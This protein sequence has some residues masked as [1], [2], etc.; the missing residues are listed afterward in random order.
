VPGALASEIS[1]PARGAWIDMVG[2]L[3]QETTG[4]LP[5]RGYR[6][7]PR[8]ATDLRLVSL[9]VESVPDAEGQSAE[10]GE[11]QSGSGPAGDLDGLLPGANG[12]TAASGVVRA[13]LVHGGW[14]E[15]GL[16][17]LLWDGRNLVGLVD[18]IVAE[19]A[20]NDALAGAGAP[21]GVQLQARGAEVG[22]A[23]LH[24][25][26]ITLRTDDRLERSAAPPAAPVSIIANARQ[27]AWARLVGM[28]T[29]Q[30]GARLLVV[31]GAK[32]VLERHCADRAD[33][34][35]HGL[36]MVEGILAARGQ[37]LVI[38]C[39]AVTNAPTLV[40]TRTLHP[41]G[42]GVGGGAKKGATL[43]VQRGNPPALPPIA[44]LAAAV[45]A[46]A[47]LGLGAWRTGLLARLAAARRA[48]LDA[49]DEGDEGSAPGEPAATSVD[50]GLAPLRLVEPVEEV[51]LPLR[52]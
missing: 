5:L 27:P 39:D 51:E 14:P 12:G 13:T 22:P 15:L 36:V 33:A 17:G 45:A 26:L 23:P 30:A 44:A 25:P 47:L 6:L 38:G 8:A 49:P 43:A 19:A 7:W 1:V 34:Q 32:L 29:S 31:D 42:D 24:L 16:A 10:S 37:R 4:A 2:V 3:G 35:R 52:R 46:L 9:P 48:P 18:G 41:L 40:A 28:L 21:I 50:G 11:P 20:V